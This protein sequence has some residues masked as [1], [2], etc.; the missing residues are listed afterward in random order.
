MWFNTAELSKASHHL[1]A[2]SA[3]LQLSKSIPQFSAPKVAKSQES[4]TAQVQPLAK[5]KQKVGAGDTATAS[6]WWLIHFRDLDPVEVACCL[7]A[8]HAEILERHPDAVA[9]E[10]FTPTLRRPSAPLTIEAE[11]AIRVWLALIEETDPATLA[12]VIGQCQRDA[13]ARDY[14]TRRAD[15]ERRE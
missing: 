14:F 4:Q 9:A 3:T 10:P 8:T 2:T 12:E 11:T 1:P 13:D 15:P 6:S 5:E 7:E